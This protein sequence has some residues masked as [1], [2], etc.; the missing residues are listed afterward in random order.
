MLDC[1]TDKNLK[2]YRFNTNIVC[3]RPRSGAPPVTGR[4]HNQYLRTYGSANAK[5]LQTLLPGVRGTRVSRQTIHNQHHHFGLNARQPLHYS[6][7]VW[8]Q[9]T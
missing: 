6:R 5:Q 4:N 1:G 3:D 8:L 7:C 9:K 2:N